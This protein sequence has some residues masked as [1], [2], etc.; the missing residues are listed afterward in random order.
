MSFERAAELAFRGHFG[1]AI[2]AADRSASPSDSAWIRA[3]VDAARGRFPR[4]ER[5]LRP[6]SSRAASPATRSRAATTLG[7][8]LRQT[9]RHAE[10]RDV[11]RAALRRER[12][13]GMRAHLLIGLVADAVGLGDL[14]AVDAAIRRV[15]PRPAGG[16]R[17]L[18]RLRWVRC[19]RELLAGRPSAAVSHARRALA[20]AERAGARR[21]EA[22][23]LL[24]LGAA[25]LDAAGRES[26]SYRAAAR[27]R[28]AGR[29][30][31]RAR[32]VAGRL[33][34]A[35][36]AVVAEQLS[37]GLGRVGRMPRA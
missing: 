2:A 1:A 36:I 14:R 25:L 16:W 26:S 27:G 4:A 32:A 30:L 3:Y 9:G 17:A 37:Q 10:A 21:H 35:P 7:S 28:E 31:R 8:V 13:P 23:S 11:E 12:A 5:A 33:G 29:A 22:K 15:G 20:I 19:E 6:L 24:F 18:V 34:A